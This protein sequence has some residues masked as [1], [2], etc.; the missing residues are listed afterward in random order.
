MNDEKWVT[1]ERTK[2][3]GSGETTPASPGSAVFAGK[4]EII[5]RQL[6]SDAGHDWT[7]RHPIS[8]AAAIGKAA[9][10]LEVAHA[11]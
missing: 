1:H 3:L 10:A 7:G 2:Y 8:L 11:H 9:K 5:R 4:C 6:Q